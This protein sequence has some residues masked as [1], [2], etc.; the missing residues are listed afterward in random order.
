VLGLAG[1][2]HVFGAMAVLATIVDFAHALAMMVWVVGLP[3]LFLHRWPRLSRAFAV[4]AV[5][6]VVIN[7]T[8]DWLIGECPLTVL[9]RLLWTHAP[10]RPANTNEWFTVR[11]SELVF[12]LTPSHESVKVVTKALVFASAVGVLYTGL[13]R[14]RRGGSNAPRSGRGASAARRARSDGSARA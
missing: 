11:F 13:K 5:V 6:F 2:L 10:T 14:R 7:V 9:A 12:G 1:M 4:Y 8:S 3:L